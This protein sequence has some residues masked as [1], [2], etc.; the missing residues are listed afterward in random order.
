MISLNISMVL[1]LKGYDKH[2]LKYRRKAAL[3]RATCQGGGHSCSRMKSIRSGYA[4]L[5]ITCSQVQ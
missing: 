1:H 3:Q 4:Q 5:Y 2:Y